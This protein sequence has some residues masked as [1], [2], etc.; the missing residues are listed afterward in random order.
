MHGNSAGNPT[1]EH[2]NLHRVGSQYTMQQNATQDS[3]E[4]IQQADPDL[5]HVFSSF[6]GPTRCLA[7]LPYGDIAMD[8]M[9]GAASDDELFERA[10]GY[11]AVLNSPRFSGYN[12]PK[13]VESLK[14]AKRFETTYTTASMMRAMY[15]TASELVLPSGARYVSAAVCACAAGSKEAE[16]ERSLTDSERREAEAERLAA[17]LERLASTWVSYMLWP[18]VANSPS[19]IKGLGPLSGL[20]TPTAD[21]TASIIDEGLSEHQQGNFKDDVKRRDGYQC[22]FT[23]YFD[24]T[25]PPEMWPDNA[26]VF[27]G[28]EAAHIFKRAVAVV[29]P[30]ENYDMYKSTVATLDILHHYCN[31]DPKIL[32]SLDE[33]HNGILLQHDTHYYFDR[34]KWCLAPT[35]M[36]NTYEICLMPRY[37]FTKPI[38]RYHTFKDH[39]CPDAAA[40]ST[41]K[42]AGRKQ[43]P[44]K[45]GIDLPNPTLLRMHAALTKV[46]HAS[47]AAEIFD[48]FRPEPGSSA[49]PVIAAEYGSSFVENIVDGK[50]DVVAMFELAQ[51]SRLGIQ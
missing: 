33:P 11:L 21:E 8:V 10:Q 34:M 48:A 24:E 31:L 15:D 18:M 3:R 42:R 51:M 28:L 32:E 19:P 30:E 12:K 16:A 2:L 5:T 7:P 1:F 49:E 6:G 41:S 40:Q 25:M 22:L 29:D 47:G 43:L 46:M 45:V 9:N 44:D 13:W 39:S 50:T 17:S 23:G 35:E 26:E 27:A 4:S 14:K 37:R 36:A 38:K 20:A